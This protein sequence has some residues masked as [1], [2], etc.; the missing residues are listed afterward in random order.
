[1][2][3][4]IQKIKDN[5]FKSASIVGGALIS[6]IGAVNSITAVYDRHFNTPQGDAETH[7]LPMAT[8]VEHDKL[9]SALSNKQLAESYVGQDIEVPVQFLGLTNLIAPPL[10]L[11]NFPK[12]SVPI[13]HFIPNAPLPQAPFGGGQTGFGLMP[14]F[15]ILFPKALAETM[16]T[17]PT[18]SEMVIQ[19]KVIKIDP[20]KKHGITGHAAVYLHASAF[21]IKK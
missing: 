8:S 15:T 17:L 11:E 20:L 6:I 21:A 10:T 1:M 12:G 2:P 14:P 3:D 13:A 18:P 9:Y 5:K 4:W 16:A 19:G 7:P